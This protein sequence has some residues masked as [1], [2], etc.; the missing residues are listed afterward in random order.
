[1]LDDALV[2][3]AVGLIAVQIDLVGVVAAAG[4]ADIGLARLAR[5]IDDAADDRQ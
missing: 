2:F 3:Q 4:E 1:M 5:A